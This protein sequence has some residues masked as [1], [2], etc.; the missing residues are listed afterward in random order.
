MVLTC[1][2]GI[3]QQDNL[4][5]THQVWHAWGNFCFV[6]HFSLF[7]LCFSFVSFTY[8]NCTRNM[9][10]SV[11]LHQYFN[12]YY[13]DLATIHLSDATYFILHLLLLFSDLIFSLP[14]H[15]IKFFVCFFYFA[16]ADCCC[17]WLPYLISIFVSKIKLL[18]ITQLYFMQA[19]AMPSS[20]HIDIFVQF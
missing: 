12:T 9:L 10:H 17:L 8:C 7:L 2:V 6:S 19:P 15:G 5:I 1:R 13:W 4:S 16:W 3:K 11:R 14:C 18:K 20:K